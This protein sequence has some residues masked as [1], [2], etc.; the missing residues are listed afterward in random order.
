MSVDDHQIT[1]DQMAD[2][3]ERPVTALT[4]G[5]CDDQTQAHCCESTSKPTCCGSDRGRD[6]ESPIGCGCQ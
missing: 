2:R 4:P 1:S 6:P 3:A 5:C